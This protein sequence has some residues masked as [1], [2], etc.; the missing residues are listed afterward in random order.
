MSEVATD[1]QLVVVPAGGRPLSGRLRAPGDKSVSHRSLLI[2]AR[3]AGRS[4]I[5]G[6]SNGVD[7][8][9]TL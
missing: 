5:R 2:A 7:V 1:K 6:L 8:R 3:A 9:H 4:R